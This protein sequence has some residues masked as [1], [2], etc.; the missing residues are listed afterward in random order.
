M[1]NFPTVLHLTP[2]SIINQLCFIFPPFSVV[3]LRHIQTESR[4]HSFLHAT[5]PG[6][7]NTSLSQRFL[8]KV[9]RGVHATVSFHREDPAQTVPVPDVDKWV[10]LSG[11][12]EEL[13]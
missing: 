3:H 2:I 4:T 11:W 6:R 10:S 13:T 9:Q 7:G 12:V 5:V 1:E 8:G